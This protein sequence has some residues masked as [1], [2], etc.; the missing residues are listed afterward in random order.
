[1]NACK[2]KIWMHVY[3]DVRPFVLFVL[4]RTKPKQSCKVAHVGYQSTRPIYPS[5][6]LSWHPKQPQNAGTLESRKSKQK[7]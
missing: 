3:D 4:T 2:L 1:M 7:K 5:F 6:F